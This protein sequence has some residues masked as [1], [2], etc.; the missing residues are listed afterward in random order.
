M[1]TVSC[2]TTFIFVTED[3]NNKTCRLNFHENATSWLRWSKTP[4]QITGKT[5]HTCIVGKRE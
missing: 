3:Y 2:E 1:K 4:D 5:L